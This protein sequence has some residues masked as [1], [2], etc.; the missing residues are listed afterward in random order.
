MRRFSGDSWKL[1]VR[2]FGGR[3]IQGCVSWRLG[4]RLDRSLAWS[5][6]LKVDEFTR[7]LLSAVSRRQ[8]EVSCFVPRLVER[9]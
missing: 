8:Q 4:V 1:W 9:R 7:Y 6:S 5:H 2:S 3:A